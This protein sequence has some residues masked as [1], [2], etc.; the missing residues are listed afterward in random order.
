MLDGQIISNAHSD[1][2]RVQESKNILLISI[3]NNDFSFFLFI[4]YLMILS[5]Y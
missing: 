1:E 2:L 4:S 5:Y 3:N